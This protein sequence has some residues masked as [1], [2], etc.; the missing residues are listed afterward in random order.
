MWWV[1]DAQLRPEYDVQLKSNQAKNDKF[2]DSFSSP[3]KG[4]EISDLS[5]MLKKIYNEMPNAC[6][7]VCNTMN[8]HP[9][10]SHFRRR[11][12]AP[13]IIAVLYHLCGRSATCHASAPPPCFVPP[14]GW[15]YIAHKTLTLTTY[16][17]S[18]IALRPFLVFLLWKESK[19]R[20]SAVQPLAM[21]GKVS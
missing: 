12:I 19:V 11:L 10:A 7:I 4:V 21:V 9:H 6:S 15:Q 20:S 17:S 13:V 2:S 5:K 18:A 14:Y 8:N 16:C 1:Q 3:V